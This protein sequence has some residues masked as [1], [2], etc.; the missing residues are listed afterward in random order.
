MGRKRKQYSE[1]FKARVALAAIREDKTQAQLAAQFGVS[2]AMIS[3]WKLQLLKQAP[4]LFSDGRKS[5]APD[6]QK[7]VSSLYEQIGRLQV[8][9]EWLKKNHDLLS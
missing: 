6:N 7:L 8:E 1:K 5:A 9:L 2:A 3:R 4:E